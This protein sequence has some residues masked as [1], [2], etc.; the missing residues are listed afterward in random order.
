MSKQS[1]ITEDQKKAWLPVIDHEAEAPI[2]DRNMRNMVTTV[3]QNMLDESSTNTTNTIYNPEYSGT[4][5]RSGYATSG[6]LDPVMIKLVRRAMPALIANDL[7]GVQAMT[8]PT[9]LIFALRSYYGVDPTTR[10]EAFAPGVGV[11]NNEFYSGNKDMGSGADDGRLTT[12]EAEQ[13]GVGVNGDGTTDGTT[14]RTAFTDATNVV[15]S[16]P[17]NEM[18][19]SIEKSS[20]TAQTRAL[21]ARY[22]DELAQ[23]LRVIHGLDAGTELSNILST[24]IVSEQNREI[25]NL[26]YTSSSDGAQN[27]VTAGLSAGNPIDSGDLGTY[28]LF[29][30]DGRW[31]QEKAKMLLAQIV[32][33]ASE[34]ARSTGRGAG[35]KILVTPMVANALDM[36]AAISN[37]PG[38]NPSQMSNTTGVGVTYAGTLLGGRFSV[39]VDQFQSVE[40][41]CVGYKGPNI[42]DAGLFYCPY[43]P[44]QPMRAMG[45][46][47]FQPRIGFKTRYGLVENPFGASNYYRKFNVVNI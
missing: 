33:E 20:V 40:Q 29:H 3:L 9:G 18:S 13:L 38:D 39:Y 26:I 2:T 41:V 37:N 7:V 17:W 6:E 46:E 22:S 35:N 23:D 16:N 25:I 31:F 15:Q 44:L 32:W 5:D 45:E 34:I 36:A 24:E 4:G 21:K 30:A 11:T 42:Y 28:S 14:A 12:A 19:F 43:V 47:D 8:G 10:T 27:S 1:I